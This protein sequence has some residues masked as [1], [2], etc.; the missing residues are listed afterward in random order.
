MESSGHCGP[1]WMTWILQMIWH[2]KVNTASTEPV[3]LE[4]SPVKEVQ[5]FTY[6]GSIINVQ[7]GTD[8]KVTRIG[9]AGT[10]FLQLQ[11]IWK[12][13]ELS[14]STKIRIFNSNVKS[15]LIYGAETWRITKATFTK[16]QTFIN[17]CLRRVLRVHWPDKISNISLW[18]RTQQIPAEQEMGRRKWRW[19]GHMLKK[20]L[21]STT[22]P[23]SWNP[24]WK[25]RRGRPRNTWR[26]DV[27]ADTKRMGITWNQLAVSR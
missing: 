19:I 11:T 8:E 5:S 16:V 3:L 20:P 7:G 17:S 18:E 21:A 14:Q 22:R 25:R 4:S 26:Q 24:Q 2:M 9:K 13:R 12:F 10:A 6:L 15:V 23:L 27:L 1:S